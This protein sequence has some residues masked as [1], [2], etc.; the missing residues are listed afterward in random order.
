MDKNIQK[1]ERLLSLMDE[2][3]LTKEDFVK[4]FEKVIEFVLKIQKEQEEAIKRLE[5]THKMLLDK[6]QYD[7]Q[8]TLS[9][10]KGQVNDVFVGDQIK[11]IDSESKM[12]H[13]EMKKVMNEIIDGKIKEVDMRI[14]KIKDGYTPIKG[15]DY[16][17]GKHGIEIKPTEIRD[18][19]ETLKD[20]DRLSIKAIKGLKE[21]LELLK[22][23]K[24]IYVGGGTANKLVA[25][26]LSSSLNGVLTTFSFRSVY[27]VIDVKLSSKPVLRLTT[28]YTWN[29]TSVT[30][31]SEISAVT[32]LAVGQSLIVIALEN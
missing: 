29:Q 5:E 26:D 17:D 14:S 15:K 19:L 2:D 30:F 25:I 32:D 27:K 11:R 8:T 10:L 9:D 22:K 12:S 6:N 31:T 13:A 4:S 28:D 1:L 24:T 18:K 16:F 20:D 7:H 21:A 3:S 23:M